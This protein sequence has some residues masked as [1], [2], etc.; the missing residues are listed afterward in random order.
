MI[1]VLQAVI[2]RAR[3]RSTSRVNTRFVQYIGHNMR[4][5]ILVYWPPSGLL[6][7]IILC[8]PTKEEEERSF[9][10]RRGSDWFAFDSSFMVVA[11]CSSFLSCQREESIWSPDSDKLAKCYGIFDL[12]ISGELNQSPSFRFIDV[13]ID[14]WV[15]YIVR[16]EPYYTARNT[17]RVIGELWVAQYR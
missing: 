14:L 1:C 2:F 16:G 9:A 8:S 6:D 7:F 17:S 15:T 13:G 3:N 12:R 11:G 10:A 5:R 4:K